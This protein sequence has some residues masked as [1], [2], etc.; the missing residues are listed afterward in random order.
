[1][2]SKKARRRAR[3]H[4]KGWL[5]HLRL[6]MKLLVAG[7][8]KNSAIGCL[9]AHYRGCT[10]W[11]WERQTLIRQGHTELNSFC[12]KKKLIVAN[13][14][15]RKKTVTVCR[16]GFFLDVGCREILILL[17]AL[18]CLPNGFPAARVMKC[19]KMFSAHTS[20]HHS[21]TW[22]D[23][24]KHRRA[25]AHTFFFLSLAEPLS[26]PFCAEQR[27]D[28]QLSSETKTN[29][30]LTA[31]WRRGMLSSCRCISPFWYEIPQKGRF[32]PSS[33]SLSKQP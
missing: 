7:G 12:G 8:G 28:C 18:S 21:D 26:F 11:G 10:D 22:V 6:W 2:C 33:S 24:R 31:S 19:L 17:T 9:C 3:T 30:L 32:S 5:F 29:T 20:I 14:A 4:T 23:W 27:P 16:K 1:M 15:N 13:L 25:R